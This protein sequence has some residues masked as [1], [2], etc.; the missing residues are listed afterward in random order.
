MQ[1]S[2]AMQFGLLALVW[3]SSFLF[4]KIALSEMLPGQVVFAR[5]VIGAL[6]LMLLAVW[7]RPRLPQTLAGWGHLVILGALWCAIPFNLFA[8]AQQQVASSL[9]SILNAT[10]PLMTAVAAWLLLRERA[11]A[12]RWVGL[13]LG[14]VGVVVIV[15][16]WRG[17]VGGTVWGQLG[18]LGATA[19]YGLGFAYYRRFVAPLQ[20]SALAT[21]LVQV[22]SAAVLASLA[23]PFSGW[24]AAV[25]SWP[26]WGALL[27]LGALGT[28]AAYV[29]NANVAN[30][31]GPTRAS[32]VTYLIPV[33]GVLLGVLLL[34]EPL[35]WAEP[36]G[37]LVVLAGV[38]VVQGRWSLSSLLASRVDVGPTRR[39][40]E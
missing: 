21:A 17:G 20:L 37:G 39:D 25:P 27:A 15:E 4:V 2:T 3:G 35:S 6:T 23:L 32:T 26:V 10:T 38:A 29:W 31:W 8:W 14:V 13:V 12:S 18:C 36:F 9:A 30:A 34:A 5:L 1:R 7:R 11:G 16:P 19:C 40:D 28:G 24:Y 22:G 33:V